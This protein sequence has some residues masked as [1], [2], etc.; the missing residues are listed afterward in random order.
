[1]KRILLC[2]VLL[3]WSGLA[4]AVVYKWIGARGNL[5]YGD[6]PPEGVH[7]EVVR[8]IGMEQTRPVPRKSNETSQSP[9]TAA[10]D[11]LANEKKIEEKAAVDQDVA[12]VRKK[13]CAEAQSHY[14]QLIDNRRLYKVDTTGE[15]EYLTSAQIDAARLSAKQD[16]DGYCGNGA[17]Q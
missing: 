12:A 4:S 14:Q 2:A 8:L 3:A 17:G 13:R 16:V 10:V 15:R 11:P 9:A 6:E 5:Q 1:M 7:A